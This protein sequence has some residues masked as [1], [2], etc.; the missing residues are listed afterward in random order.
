MLTC[1]E[2]EV[3]YFPLDYGLSWHVCEIVLDT[4]DLVFHDLAKL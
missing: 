2:P 1:S 4:V 3:D